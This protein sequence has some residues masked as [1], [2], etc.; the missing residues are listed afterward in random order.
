PGGVPVDAASAKRFRSL[1]GFDVPAEPG[2]T[3]VEALDEALEGRIDGLYCIGG[4]F[5]ET[6]P[7]PTR[8]ERALARIPVRIH[9][10]IVVTSQMLVDPKETVYLLPAQT[11]YEQK[12]GGT[13]T[14]TERRVVF[15][16]QIPGRRVG[17]ARSEW[18][19]L[20]DFARAVRPEQY[21]KVHFDSTAE[22]RIEIEQAVPFYR[23]IAA[24]EKQ[25][26]QFQWGGERLCEGRSFPTADGKASF[27]PVLATT[28]APLPGTFLLATRRG[29]QFN[30]MIQRDRDPLTG[31]DRDHVFV[32]REDAARLGLAGDDPLVLRNAHGEL[33]GRAFLADVAP[34]TLQA[35]WPEAN[36]LIPA[37]RVAK[38]GGV[39]DYNAEVTIE[40]GARA[41][42]QR[43]PTDGNR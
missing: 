28:S 11:R 16:P 36:V 30:S 38:D 20:L 12:G 43:F 25:G 41:T 7:D 18:E 42:S 14:T 35:H 13:E 29:K 33:R 23:G 2:L 40:Y 21:G 32:S 5:L 10:D 37:G 8:I 6:M 4:N 27:R 31:A 39:P 19:M 9:S 3:T 15:S 17:E 26:D 1:W 24:M 34:G 22:I